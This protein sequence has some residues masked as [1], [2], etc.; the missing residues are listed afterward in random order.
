MKIDKVS[1]SDTHQLT[2]LTMQS[3]AY[4]GYAPEQIEAWREALTI[5]KDYLKQAEVYKLTQ[6][7]ELIGY[8][9]Y[10]RL[11]EQTAKL[12]NLF[13]DPKYI[14]KGFGKALMLHFIAQ[15]KTGGYK[16]ITLESEPNAA[17]FYEQFGFKI[18]GQMETSIPNRYLPTMELELNTHLK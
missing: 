18:V 3:K 11:D 16:R 5:T 8:Y 6:S 9:S 13:I 14:R 17:E 1:D 2:L 15:V 10:K 12:D 4:W 7:N